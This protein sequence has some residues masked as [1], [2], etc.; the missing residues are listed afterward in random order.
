[1][2]S[3]FPF[4]AVEP[5]ELLCESPQTPWHIEDLHFSS[6]ARNYFKYESDAKY[7]FT[8]HLDTPFPV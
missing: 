7:I 6:P 2:K 4:Q 8:Q 1:M 5:Y 3:C